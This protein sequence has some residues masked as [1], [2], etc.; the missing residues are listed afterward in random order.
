MPCNNSGMF[1]PK[2]GGRFG[3]VSY[4]WSNA[5]QLWANAKPMDCERLLHKQA[6]L[7]KAHNPKSK[8][9]VYR[10]L[11]SSCNG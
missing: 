10:N 5:K 1:D 3:A 9:W 7:T 6:M 2:F 8:T 11:V 4:D